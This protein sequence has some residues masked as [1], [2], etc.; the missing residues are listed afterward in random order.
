MNTVD[1]TI[2]DLGFKVESADFSIHN[3]TY[4]NKKSGRKVTIQWDNTDSECVMFCEDVNPEVDD[5]GHEISVSCGIDIIEAQAFIDKINELRAIKN[6]VTVGVY[7]NGVY[8]H[9]IVRDEDLLSHIEYNKTFRFGRGLFVDGVCVNQG[10]LS[11]EQVRNW[12]R[13]IREMTFDT[14]KP[15]IPYV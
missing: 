1:K 7:Q 14:S 5:F 2:E 9:N 4:V 11:G 10:Y 8:K 15:T 12:T 13:R 3:I 6:H